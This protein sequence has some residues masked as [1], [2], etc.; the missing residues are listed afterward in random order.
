[1]RLSS[2]L[3]AKCIWLFDMNLLNPKG[4]APRPL[5]EALKEHYRFSKAPSHMG[6]TGEE[7]NL[8]FENGEFVT[9]D[10]RTISVTL[11]IFNDG[12]VTTN[13]SSTA[14]G[15]AFL[16]DVGLFVSASGFD[17]PSQERISKGY[18]S[19]LQVES[20]KVLL[21]LNP[22]LER[23]AKFLESNVVPMDG[24]ARVFQFTSI[25]FWSEDVTKYAAPTSFKFERKIGRPFESNQYYSEAPLQT[26]EHLQLLEQL[27]EILAGNPI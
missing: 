2:V 21:H 24:R 12:I 1:M 8:S 18:A 6:D 15:T 3:N 26:H 27:E 4:L 17:F 25:G 9:E 20:D 7:K 14:D 22:K 16:E 13:H 10:G 19:T 23:I 5:F 11:K